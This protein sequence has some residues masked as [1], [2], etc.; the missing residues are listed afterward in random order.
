ML[1]QRIQE[2]MVWIGNAVNAVEI[3]LKALYWMA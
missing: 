3:L 1:N 2:K